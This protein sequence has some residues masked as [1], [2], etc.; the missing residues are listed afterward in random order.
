MHSSYTEAGKFTEEGIQTKKLLTA[1]STNLM[2]GNQVIAVADPVESYEYSVSLKTY[3]FYENKIDLFGY[4]M[5][6]KESS[7]DYQEYVDGWRSY[8]QGK[9]FE[10]LT[11]KPQLLIFFD[12]RMIDDFFI[13]SGLSRSNYLPVEIGQSHFALLKENIK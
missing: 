12:N 13:R 2:P 11:S 9:Q 10:D 8:F 3:L 4:A 6:N 5:I 1:I 7:A